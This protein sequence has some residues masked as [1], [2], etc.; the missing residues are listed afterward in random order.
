MSFCSQLCDDDDDD[1]NDDNNDD[2]NNDDDNDDDDDSYS[3]FKRFR[4]S[5]FRLPRTSSK[6]RQ[7]KAVSRTRIAHETLNFC[8]KMNPPTHSHVHAH[9]LAHTHA[10]AH[11]HLHALTLEQTSV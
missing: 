7:S 5:L 4:K 6:S 3:G 9:T 2:N 1:D 10:L 8:L 11:T